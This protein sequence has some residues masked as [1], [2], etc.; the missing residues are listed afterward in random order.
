MKPHWETL[1]DDIQKWG[2]EA[3]L[4]PRYLSS[5]FYRGRAVSEVSWEWNRVKWYGALL[6][7]QD[8]RWFV[9]SHLFVNPSL[10]TEDMFHDLLS[11]LLE[12]KACPGNGYVLI[13]RSPKL[14]KMAEEFAFREM[15]GTCGDL[16]ELVENLSIVERIPLHILNDS[17]ITTVGE[18]R[19]LVRPPLQ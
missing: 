10:G 15:W 18:A 7:T 9:I 6:K 5:L 4:T 14:I 16:E 17:C 8:P 3:Y 12:L 19:L 1:A 11:K 13:A 2:G